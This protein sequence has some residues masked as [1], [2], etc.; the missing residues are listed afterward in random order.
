MYS[1]P[2]HNRNTHMPLKE[3]TRDCEKKTGRR[4]KHNKGWAFGVDTMMYRYNDAYTNLSMGANNAVAASCTCRWADLRS[5]CTMPISFN[6]PPPWLPMPPECHMIAASPK[7][8]HHTILETKRDDNVLKIIVSFF[9]YMPLCEHFVK[10]KKNV[11]SLKHFRFARTP[12]FWFCPLR[13]NHRY[14]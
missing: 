5:L 9:N 4:R 7:A 8:K 2:N 6:Q 1:N 11:S 3:L 14:I 10:R 13:P 12:T